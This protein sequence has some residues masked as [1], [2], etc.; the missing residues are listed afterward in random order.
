MRRWFLGAAVIALAI[1]ATDALENC[2]SDVLVKA[3]KGLNVNQQLVS[4]MTQNNFGAALDGSVDLSIMSPSSAPD[5]IKAICAADS[6][7]TILSALASSPNFEL[8]NC[9]VGNNVVLKTE[10]SNL[11]ETCLALSSPASDPS[12]PTAVTSLSKPATTTS[13]PPNGALTDAPTATAP[14]LP[15][16]SVAITDAQTD[17]ASSDGPEVLT[18]APPTVQAPTPVT[19][20]PTPVTEAPTPV[21]EAPTPV[22]EAPT[23][24]QLTI[25]KAPTVPSVTEAPIPVAEAPIV[26]SVPAVPETI[27]PANVAPTI[28]PATPAPTDAPATAAPTFL[29]SDDTMQM[30]LTSIEPLGT[31]AHVQQTDFSTLDSDKGF[32]SGVFPSKYC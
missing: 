6:C 9:I 18:V 15:T 19:E 2:T 29:P 25:T 10:V 4:C 3:Y 11:Q 16:E 13:T 32:V 8:T 7:T 14:T 5:H 30:E 20:A 23:K 1:S 17:A 31:M 28:A 12:S 27:A 26:A 21:T 24:S 22:T